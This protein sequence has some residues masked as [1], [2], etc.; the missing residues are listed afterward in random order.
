MG[1]RKFGGG[2]KR[3]SAYEPNGI[4]VDLTRGCGGG[5]IGGIIGGI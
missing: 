4:V 3:G 5:I 2:C 1:G